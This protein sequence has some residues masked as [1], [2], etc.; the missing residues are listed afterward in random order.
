MARRTVVLAVLV[1]AALVA[2]TLVVPPS[3][4]A[5]SEASPSTVRYG[6]AVAGP[7]L[8]GF[9]PPPKPWMAGNRGTDYQVEPGSPVV[10][11]AEGE[12][13]FA[14]AVAGALHVTVRHPDGLRTSYSFLAEVTVHAGQKVVRGQTVGVAGGPVHVGVRT[15]DGTYLDPQALLSGA[16]RPHV[17][18]VPGTDDGLDPLAERRS[19]LDVVLDGGA[20]AVAFVAS[21]GADAL[22]L[23]A[24]YAAELDPATHALRAADAAV[25]WWRRNQRCTAPG[26]PLPPPA[27][28][29]IVVLVS[30][31]GSHSEGNT[32]VE[33]PVGDLGY[34]RD[35]VV[36]FSYAGGRA[37]EPELP[38]LTMVATA[39][40]APPAGPDPFASIPERPFSKADSQQSLGLAADRLADLLRQV[41]AAQPGVPIDVVAHSQGGVV[42]RLGIER[43]GAAAELPPEVENLVTLG[44]PHQGAPLG[45]GVEALKVSGTGSGA[46]AALRQS[47]RLADL[48]ERLPAMTDLSETSPVIAEL[49]GTPMPDGVRFTSI[50]AAGDVVV[51]GT[52]TADR[53][54]DSHV[55]VPSDIGIDPHSALATDPRVVREIG[56]AVTGRPPSCQPFGEALRGFLE[57]ELIRT[58]EGLSSGYLSGLAV[59][60]DVVTGPGT[61]ARVAVE[62]D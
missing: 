21:E 59:Q 60:S 53:Q 33:I 14:G 10:A 2:T 52:V 4:A 58:G 23:V 1:V 31:L 7:V 6:P 24:H 39:P 44:S 46:L 43:A 38:E 28:H 62:G 9:D 16:L 30:G 49:Q 61:V 42:A 12:V 55:I 25:E 5:A 29:R 3:A 45:T 20:A 50:G 56:L 51:P 57:A 13:V 17:V 47:Q 11:A 32:S 15:P 19:L 22:A 40:D 41:A 35:E 34:R 27:E 37:P 18:L 26:D 54:A 48:D 8:E 36:R